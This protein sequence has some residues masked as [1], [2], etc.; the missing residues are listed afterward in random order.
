MGKSLHTTS[1]PSLNCKR[2]LSTP[3]MYT[4]CCQKAYL[5]EPVFYIIEWD[6]HIMLAQLLNCLASSGSLSCGGIT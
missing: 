2:L 6:R 5:H 1:P 3:W 4:I